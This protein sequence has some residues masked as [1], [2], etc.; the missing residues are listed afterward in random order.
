VFAGVPIPGVAAVCGLYGTGLLIVGLAVVHRTTPRR[1]ALA[2]IV[3]ATLVFGVGFGAIA[4]GETVV[5]QLV[6]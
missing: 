4:A 1:A 6:G 2:G 5:A 3:P